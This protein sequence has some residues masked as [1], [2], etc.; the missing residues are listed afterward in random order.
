MSLNKGSWDDEDQSIDFFPLFQGTLPFEEFDIFSRVS[1]EVVFPKFQ[2]FSLSPIIFP[3]FQGVFPFFG[4]GFPFS[5]SDIFWRTS[6]GVV[7]PWFQWFSPPCAFL[8]F[9]MDFS[10]CLNPNVGEFSSVLP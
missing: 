6:G 2:C 9:S 10:E 4:D 8:I 1:G 7:L 3:L 5:E